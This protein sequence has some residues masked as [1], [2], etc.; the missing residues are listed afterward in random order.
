MHTELSTA[1]EHGR[2][3]WV[4]PILSK[5]KWWFRR[6]VVAWGLILFLFVIPW[7][8]IK[9]NQSI[10]LDFFNGKIHFFGLTLWAHENVVVLGFILFVLALILL[11]TAIFGR[12]FCGWACP[13]TVFM[14]YVY[15]PVERLLEGMGLAQRKFHSLPLS[16]RWPRSA[17]KL[18][19][20]AV[21]SLAIANTMIAYVFGR[22]TVIQMIEDGPFSHWPSFFGMSIVWGLVFFQFTWFREQMCT[23]VCPYGRLQ[24]LLLDKDSLIVAYDKIRGEPRGKPSQVTGDCVDCKMCI[25]VCPTG[26]DIRNGLQLECIH[27]TA[28][29]DACDAVMTKLKRP[30]GLIRYQ[31]EME[32]EGKK[33]RIIRPRLAIYSFVLLFASALLIGFSAGRTDLYATI[34]RETGSS[35]MFTET[36]DGYIINPLKIH[37]RNRDDDEHGFSLKALSPQGMELILPQGS[38]RLKPGE[39]Q[40]VH[41]LAKLPKESFRGMGGKIPAEIELFESDQEAEKHS[42]EAHDIQKRQIHL[43]IFGPLL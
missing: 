11:V 41:L 21:I 10:Q 24:S 40:T 29:M 38:F 22:E 19:I 3:K 32:V 9:E 16:K 5:G 23:F 36:P 18:F 31:T 27:C 6:K 4:Y 34:H 25:H 7:T 33:R 43:E 8:K 26:I 15:R 35:N 39:K 14:E 12:I 37:I 13:M 1:D 20:F 2:R 28:C 17:V 42:E 30:L